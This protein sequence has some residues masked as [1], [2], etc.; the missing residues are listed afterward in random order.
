MSRP[1]L[2]P[3]KP[4][5]HKI[6]VIQQDLEQTL[7][8]FSDKIVSLK[9]RRTEKEFDVFPIHEAIELPTGKKAGSDIT[10]KTGISAQ[11]VRVG[12]E[13]GGEQ[14]LANPGPRIGSNALD[15]EKINPEPSRGTEN[16]PDNRG[17][18]ASLLQ[19][20]RVCIFP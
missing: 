12:N 6:K 16:F 8:S 3:Q 20:K 15:V 9:H 7:L 5:P 18:I 2:I 10:D 13:A 4:S 11:I 19:L 1:E 14:L 17:L